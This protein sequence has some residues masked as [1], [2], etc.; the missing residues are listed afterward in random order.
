MNIYFV[1][2]LLFIFL[3]NILDNYQNNH[4]NI[5]LI[6][7]NTQRIMI[8]S[9][10]LAQTQNHNPHYHNDPELKEIIDKLNEEAIKK[11]QKTHKLYEQLH[12][13]VEKK[14][15]KNVGGHVAEPISTIEKDLLEIYEEM[16]GDKS[17]IML[18]SDIYTNENHKSNDKNDKS[19]E[20]VNKKL[21]DILPSTNEVHDKYLD[22]L[23]TGFVGGLGMC[24]LS[25]ALVVKYGIAAAA[26]AA[27]GFLGSFI[28]SL[29]IESTKLINILN[30]INF[31]S[32]TSMH[33][34]FPS[35]GFTSYESGTAA[36]LAIST[37]YPYAMAIIAIIAVTI[38]VILLYVWLR[39]RRKNSWKHECKKHLCT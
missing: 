1:K 31:F 14:G 36:S 3:I 39:K 8:K 16:F 19:C 33:A 25:S 7:N 4:Y 13:L 15:N 35:A 23:K 38:I 26:S 24:A 27:K 11:Y 20:C 10:L 17:H 28:S 6:S 12:E 9:R 22:N 2:M 30:G 37:F 5:R 32:S 34:A 21:S 18:K 29:G